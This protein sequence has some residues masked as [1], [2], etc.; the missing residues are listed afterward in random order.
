MLEPAATVYCRK[1][2]ALVVQGAT[3]GAKNQYEEMSG[4]DV[5]ITVEGTLADDRCDRNT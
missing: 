3:R 2:D 4:R 1:K 5:T